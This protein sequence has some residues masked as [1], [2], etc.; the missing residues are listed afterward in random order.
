MATKKTAAKKKTA[1]KK[2]VAKKAAVAVTEPVAEAEPKKR[3]KT[4]TKKRLTALLDLM[5]MQF[6]EQLSGKPLSYSAADGLRMMQMRE[7]AEP[8]RPTEVK[9][10]WVEEPRP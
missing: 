4:Y 1:V 10:G 8:E 6:A 5:L 9:V 2:T 3:K 7:N